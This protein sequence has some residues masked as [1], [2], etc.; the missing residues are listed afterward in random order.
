MI[1]RQLHT[2]KQVLMG[3]PSGAQSWVNEEFV[4]EKE[5]EGYTLA[6]KTSV[7]NPPSAAPDFG[8]LSSKNKKALVAIGQELG[9]NVDMKM[10]KDEMIIA[11]EGTG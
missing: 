3:E 9:L 10:K 4:G 5:A 11:I 6:P 2:Q 7:P 8:D 1:T